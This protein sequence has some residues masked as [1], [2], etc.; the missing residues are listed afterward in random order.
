MKDGRSAGALEVRGE[1]MAVLSHSV[2]GCAVGYERTSSL[3]TP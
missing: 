3:L 2:Q 1:A